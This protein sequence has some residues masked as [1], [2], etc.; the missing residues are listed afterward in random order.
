MHNGCAQTFHRI[1]FNRCGTLRSIDD[2]LWHRTII[3]FG[4]QQQFSVFH[5]C[6][7][8]RNSNPL[9]YFLNCA[10]YN[11]A[12]NV[13]SECVAFLYPCNYGDF[14]AVHY[15]SDKSDQNKNRCNLLLCDYSID[16]SCRIFIHFNLI[17]N[18]FHIT[19]NDKTSFSAIFL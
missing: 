19:E 14:V 12:Q 1:H 6:K 7:L 15:H 5:N 17:K 3:P 16:F 13:I 2:L 10:D 4:K 8:N 9:R 11:I 18:A